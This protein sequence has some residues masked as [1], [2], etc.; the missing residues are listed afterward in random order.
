M[1]RRCA[2]AGIALI[3]QLLF[4]F[5]RATRGQVVH[6]AALC[7][8]A[9]RHSGINNIRGSWVW[10]ARCS[11]RSRE[12][13]RGVSPQTIHADGLGIAASSIRREV[14]M[15][16]NWLNWTAVIFTILLL[17]AGHRLFGTAKTTVERPKAAET[18]GV[19][20]R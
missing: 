10:Q 17:I 20:V 12:K 3:V 5:T 2:H 1:S 14:R 7:S 4:A 6:L 9:I 18:V 11:Q 13:N 16:R 19:Q 8:M 15:R